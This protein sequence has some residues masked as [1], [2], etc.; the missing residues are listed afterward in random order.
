M[1]MATASET[2]V[3]KGGLCVSIDALRLLW[4]FENRGCIVR[5][6]EDGTLFV[7]PRHEIT[8]ADV[9]RIREHRDEPAGT[10][11]LLRDRA[12]SS[13]AGTYT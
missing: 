1:P 13:C 4:A 6:E 10:R 3:L 11:E 9:E 5:R 12:M 8:P 7:G 2:V